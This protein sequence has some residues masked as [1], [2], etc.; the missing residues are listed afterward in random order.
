LWHWDG[1]AIAEVS[2]PKAS[3]IMA[4]WGTGPKDVFAVGGDGTILHYDGAAWSA[5]DSGTSVQLLDVMGSGP[6]DVW[7]V[8]ANGTAL[9]YTNG[10]WAPTAT[11][12]SAMIEAVYAAAGK[13]WAPVV[14]EDLLHWDG[15]AWQRIA[16]VSGGGDIAGL[17]ENDIYVVGDGSGSE[18]VHWDGLLWK[19]V[20]IGTRTRQTTVFGAGGT[21]WTAG[22]DGVILENR[23]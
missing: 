17:G 19:D 23:P 11:G 20:D 7:A 13:A 3:L 2:A 16:S 4:I 8:G 12:S 18:V 5:M 22:G 21:F 9:R 14:G 6:N 10:A 1:T 15:S